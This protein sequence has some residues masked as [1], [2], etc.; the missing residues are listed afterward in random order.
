VRISRVIVGVVVCAAV[1]VYFD[2]REDASQFQLE[3]RA[4]S[5]TAKKKASRTG[6]PAVKKAAPRVASATFTK[7]RPKGISKQAIK[8]NPARGSGSED[9]QTINYLFVAGVLDST[10][11]RALELLEQYKYHQSNAETSAESQFA[12]YT[13]RTLCSGVPRIDSQ[14]DL[15]IWASEA[16]SSSDRIDE[17]VEVL[18]KDVGRCREVQ[19]YVGYEEIADHTVTLSMLES[20]ADNGHPV[21]KLVWHRSE[22]ESLGNAEA[23]ELFREAYA[24][25]QDYL[26]YKGEVYIVAISYLLKSVAADERRTNTNYLA[27]RYMALREMI[28]YGENLDPEVVSADL[29]AD[30]QSDFL[31]AEV[32]W[33]LAKVT[34]FSEAMEN[35][36]WSFLGLEV[37]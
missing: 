31:P 8:A 13:I 15:D 14:E 19:K 32:D 12:L 34:K 10:E 17:R 2:V 35:G 30:L 22:L 5:P 27:L 24:Y 9:Y 6:S 33:I 21:A 37:G 18:M 11:Q 1:P 26:Q 29:Q 20:A 7:K 28:V 23:T 16:H 25:S 36:D 3:A 4:A